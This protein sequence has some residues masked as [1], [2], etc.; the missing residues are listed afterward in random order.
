LQEWRVLLQLLEQ[1]EEIAKYAAATQALTDKP[2]NN[3]SSKPSW[4]QLISQMTAE[5]LLSVIRKARSGGS[6]SADGAGAAIA[7]AERDALLSGM[8]GPAVLSEVLDAAGGAA[9]GEAGGWLRPLKF[10]EEQHR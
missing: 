10:D 5:E 4:Q 8:P 6:G 9:V 1:Y 3:S 2:N 7:A